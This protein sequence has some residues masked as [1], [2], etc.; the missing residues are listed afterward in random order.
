EIQPGNIN[1]PPGTIGETGAAGLPVAASD[2]YVILKDIQLAGK[3]RMLI[4]DFLR[5]YRLKPE[6]ILK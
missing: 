1:Q 4:A 5:G 6:T 2:G 3:K